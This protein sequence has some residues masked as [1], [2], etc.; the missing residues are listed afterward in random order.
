MSNEFYCK[1]CEITCT[2]KAPYEQHLIGVKHLRKAK[3]TESC[4]SSDQSTASSF[5]EAAINDNIFE[6]SSTSSSSSSSS[7]SIS[8]ET[9]R[10]LLEWNHPDGYKPYCD[11]CQL[12]LHG[13]GVADK[14]FSLNNI[15][16]NQK[17]SAWKK[18]QDKDVIY[19]CTTCSEIFSNENLM[20]EH[21]LSDSHNIITQQKNHLKKFIQIYET[22]NKLKQARIEKQ[23]H[24]DVQTISHNDDDENLSNQFSKLNV[25]DGTQSKIK[26]SKLGIFS[27]QKLGEIMKSNYRDDDD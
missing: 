16:H 11:I 14:H 1:F 18:I 23:N 21:F 24:E 27:Q 2:G 12:P 6:D 20:R 5:P 10:I 4:T 7:I 13:K 19:F 25:I 8:P 22:Y 15:L 9:M 17:L 3:L 26:S